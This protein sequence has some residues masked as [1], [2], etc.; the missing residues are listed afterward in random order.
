AAYSSSARSYATLGAAVSGDVSVSADVSPNG[1]RY[2]GVI[3]R[4]ASADGSKDHY[5]GWLDPNGAVHLARRNGYVYSYLADGAVSPIDH[6]LTLK[7]TGSG[8]SVQVALLVDGVPTLSVTDSS[9]QA[10]SGPGKVGLF[11]YQGSGA[12]FDNFL[13]SAP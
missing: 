1:L 9:A 4:A 5:A 3:A 7:V 2:A 10:L 6:R 12:A 13:V 8:A 11:E